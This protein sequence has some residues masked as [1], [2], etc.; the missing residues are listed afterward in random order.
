[1]DIIENK[2]AKSGLITIDLEKFDAQQ[3]IV[4]FDLKDYLH[5][6]L[7]LREKEFRTALDETD[8]SQYEGKAVA[9]FC[10]TDAIL[11]HWAFMLVSSKL[12][13]IAARVHFGT[14]E[15]I[16]FQMIRD[17]LRTHDWSQYSGKRILLKGCSDKEL[18]AGI[19]LE[20]QMHLQPVADRVMYGEACS[21][22]PVYRAPKK[23]K[24]ST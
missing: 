20:A 10:S 7:I 24:A 11:A 17:N 23:T 18:P 22:V 21:F 12:F 1:M 14:P 13:G 4:S 2:V 8:W 3:E 6:E 16:R 15:Q 5:M 9:V 19:Y